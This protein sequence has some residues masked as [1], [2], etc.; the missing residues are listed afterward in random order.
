MSDGLGCGGV[1]QGGDGT[2]AGTTSSTPISG[3]V[4]GGAT[5]TLVMAS[6]SVPVTAY[7]DGGI[8]IIKSD[9]IVPGG[10]TTLNISGVG[11]I[12]VARFNTTD[13]ETGDM[14][15]DVEISF[16]FNAAEP[17]FQSIALMAS[18]ISAADTN[19]GNTD[20]A[21]TPSSTTRELDVD[22]GMLNIT[23]DAAAPLTLLQIENPNAGGDG[24][25]R[26]KSGAQVMLVGIDQSAL[27]L[28]FG[29][30]SSNFFVFTLAGF[31]G[32][33][34]EPTSQLHMVF[35]RN[36]VGPSFLM[37]NTGTGDTTHAVSDGSEDYAWGI[38][39]SANTWMLARATFLDTGE[40]VIIVNASKNVGI[41][42]AADA[43]AA[44]KVNGD[45]LITG[46]LIVDGTKISINTESVNVEDNHLYVNAG[47]TV[48][49]AQTGGL[50]VNYLPTATIDTVSSGAFVAGVPATSNPTVATVGAATFSVSDIIQISGTVNNENDGLFEVLSHA[51]NVLTIRGVGTTTT[52]E[53]F[54]DNQFIAN[55]SDSATITKV[56]VSAIRAG[57]DGIWETAS[58]S[59]TGF[60]FNNLATQSGSFTE[61]SVL[62]ADSNGDISQ[63]NAN[64][65][66]NDTINRL[67]IGTNSPGRP[68]E[69][70]AGV[71]GATSS[72][73]LR[74]S[75]SSGTDRYD[76]SLETDDF[77]RLNNGAN[78]TAIMSWGKGGNVGI[79]IE[80]PSVKL[81]VNG[82]ASAGQQYIGSTLSANN[83]DVGFL[84]FVGNND[85]AAE[86]IY[87]QI[88]GCIDTNDAGD[89]FGELVFRTMQGGALEEHIRLADGGSVVIGGTA[90]SDAR[91]QI[92]D[93]SGNV[94]VD[95]NPNGDSYFNGGM[96]G[97]GTTTPEAGL[98]IN[99]SMS[100]KVTDV[101]AATYT[102]LTTDN[103]ISVLHTATA[104]VVLD[105]PLAAGALNQVI[106]VKDAGANASVNNID[107]DRAGSDTIIDDATG[108]TQVSIDTNGGS[109]SFYNDGVSKWFTY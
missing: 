43:V 4:T 12:E 76:F 10:A 13:P 9:V 24:L 90:L 85:S 77:L 28:K 30:Q 84:S 47:Y 6:P 2:G 107:I 8:Y 45:A 63:D 105:L 94:D 49:A 93:S 71:A 74:L 103:I 32:L 22:G 39:T 33:G 21:I 53:D 46:N 61:G 64:I 15:A 40:A 17:Q 88:F 72:R 35:A 58:G 42:G 16:V 99:T 3:G 69:I 92:K 89:E 14:P 19:I 18:E 102:I 78:D 67:G 108:L 26:F 106:T 95:L 50:V 56:T 109:I 79:N 34:V 11:A 38:D 5:N 20:L 29:P 83:S 57:T 70:S 48:A 101:D 44:F 100:R 97:V 73:V 31:L 91:V 65:F 55:A 81:H 36:D 96:L 82:G 1:N 86:T 104:S 52:V 25:M 68:L 23:D 37:D 75:E 51:G 98:S 80:V 27:A 7:I 66:W 54:T 62:F 87:A 59:V 41:K 60:T